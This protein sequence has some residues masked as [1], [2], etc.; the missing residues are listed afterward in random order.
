MGLS[1]S[2]YTAF[3]KCPKMLWLD[4][5]SPELAELDPEREQRFIEGN[6]VGDLAMGLFGEYSEVTRYKPD[7]SLDL[8]AMIEETAR[9]I[10]LGGDNICEAAFSYDDCYCAV[11]ILR[12]KRN[13][14][15]I[16]EVK[17]GTHIKDIHI[18]DIA[19]QKWVLEHC[20]INVT[21]TYLVK[22]DGR[23]VRRGE[24]DIRRLFEVFDVS[25]AVGAYFHE[26]AETIARAKEY[27]AREREPEMKIGVH[28]KEHY[29]CPY[30]K[31]CRGDLPSPNVFDLYR[32]IFAKALEYYDNGIVSYSDLVEKGVKLSA[33]QKRQVEHELGQL[34]TAVDKEGVRKF[35]AGLGYPLYF[36]D[37]ETF[38]A[39][40][41]RFDGLR[42]YAPVPFQYSLHY[43]EREDGELKHKEF[44]ADTGADPRRAIAESL[45]ENIPQNATVLAY[46][47]GF[48]CGRIHELA[49]RFP[50][51]AAPLAVIADNI[52]DL[53]DVFRGGL[54]YDRRMGGSF[55]IKS[56]LPA[57]FPDDPALD[58]HGLVGVHNGA[59]ANN[60]FLMLPSLPEKEREDL[61]QSL[62]AYC[63]L[64]TMAMVM[65]WQRLREY[66]A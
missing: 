63:K 19:Y 49:E 59:E 24:L 23:Y 60:A 32:I 22:V 62:L 5:H 34:P 3:C 57:L 4:V 45:V 21:G 1:K 42:P 58:Y 44:L 14:Y 35:L 36:L 2:K 17:S 13:G 41:P 6:E 53:L 25:F 65:L 38:S 56:V 54:V 18:W 12:R 27:V 11:D 28:C 20:G 43:I 48:E 46:N 50:D 64:D 39:C 37:F 15:A 10:A 55:S 29:S 7:G 51:L 33:T 16:Y 40:V 26:V 31:H 9:L 66:A 61:R 30:F 47:K 52:K 8:Q